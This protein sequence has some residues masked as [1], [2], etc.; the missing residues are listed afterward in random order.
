MITLP[1][2][3]QTRVA[4]VLFDMDGVLA[5]NTHLHTAAWIAYMRD[6][7][8]TP[9]DPEAPKHFHGRTAEVV[10]RLVARPLTPDE[11]RRHHEGKE[12]AYRDLA[13]GKLVPV[14]GLA[15]YLDWLEARGV[16]KAVVTNSDPVCMNFVLGELDL[17]HRFDTLVHVDQVV[18]AKP[19]PEPYLLAAS[20]LGVDPRACLVHEDSAGGV[21]AGQAAGARVVGICTSL[22]RHALLDAG[23]HDAVPDFQYWRGVLED[24]RV[25]QVST[26]LRGQACAA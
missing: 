26:R 14:R 5:D 21:R 9:L 6:T 18:N 24:M 19:H 12:A 22:P 17:A 10:E 2:S 1:F 3:P 15:D 8:G 16:R 7:F 23:A 25:D 13:R 4:A 20:R 11:A